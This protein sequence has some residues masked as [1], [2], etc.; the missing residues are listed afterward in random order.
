MSLS[1]D[2][3]CEVAAETAA[4]AVVEGGGGDVGAGSA[5]ED[6]ALP[7]HFE[8]VRQQ[9]LSDGFVPAVFNKGAVFLSNIDVRSQIYFNLVERRLVAFSYFG[10]RVQGPPGIVHGGAIFSV[11]DT[12]LALC[13]CRSMDCLAFTAN[14]SI[15]YRGP[16]KLC[17]WLQTD[18]RVDKVEKEKK[19]FLQFEAATITAPRPEKAAGGAEAAVASS[20][21]TVKVVEG[22][23]LFIAVLG[24]PTSL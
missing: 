17:Q 9:L 10:E 14:I 18:V 1:A 20:P 24:K 11:V 19:V 2:S 5:A 12:M 21:P 22:S 6:P 3:S 8:T 13:A 7:P 15:D 4:A 23:S 16:L